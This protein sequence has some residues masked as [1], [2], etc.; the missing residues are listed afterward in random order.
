MWCPNSPF[1]FCTST[2][3]HLAMPLGHLTSDHYVPKPTFCFRVVWF[4]RTQSKPCSDWENMDLIAS[5][6]VRYSTSI[7]V[8]HLFFF[9]GLVMEFFVLEFDVCWGLFS[10]HQLANLVR[11]WLRGQGSILVKKQIDYST[12]RNLFRSL[13]FLCYGTLTCVG[14]PLFSC[15]TCGDGLYEWITVQP[16]VI[17]TIL[18]YN[19]L[20]IY[21]KEE[22]SFSVDC[23]IIICSSLVDML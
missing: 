13:F 23:W 18:V 14:L 5:C 17:L 12:L 6:K 2:V 15:W 3:H 22:Y 20:Y 4:L 9:F 10:L 8:F 11:S 19:L 21:K 7:F 16:D 1:P